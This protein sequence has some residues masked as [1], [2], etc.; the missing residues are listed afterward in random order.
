MKLIDMATTTADGC[1]N[2]IGRR[3]RVLQFL[4]APTVAPRSIEPAASHHPLPP[5]QRHEDR[6]Q[7]RH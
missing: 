1:R 5:H 2:V 3:V 7:K 4:E 6:V